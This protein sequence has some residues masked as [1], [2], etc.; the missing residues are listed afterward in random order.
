MSMPS[1]APSEPVSSPGSPILNI[2][3]WLIAFLLYAATTARDILPADSGEFQLIAAG[4]GVGHPPGYPLYTVIA[5]LWAG[6][7]TLVLYLVFQ[8]AFGIG[9][10]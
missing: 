10:G 6:T 7:F 4:W 2:L 8:A 1:S 3:V 9:L 5:A